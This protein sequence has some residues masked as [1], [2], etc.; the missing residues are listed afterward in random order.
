LFS[1]LGTFLEQREAKI[2]E[3]L[4]KKNPTPK[5]G[6]HST[7]SITKE[8]FDKMS[9]YERNQLFKENEDLYKQMI[10]KGE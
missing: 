3:E 4:I 6:S 1:N 9:L 10:G 7:T 8:Q 2:K 5:G